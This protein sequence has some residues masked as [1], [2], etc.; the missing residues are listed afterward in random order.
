MGVSKFNN[1]EVSYLRKEIMQAV[2]TL[3]KHAGIKIELGNIRFTENE[4]STKMT[5]K[6]LDYAGEMTVCPVKEAKAAR[7][8]RVN[9][10]ATFHTGP[11]IGSLVDV[12]GIGEAKIIDFNSRASKVPFIVETTT[13]AKYRTSPM[14]IKAFL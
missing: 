2:K 6:R 8:I 7:S 12:L 1:Y 5:V 4:F 14:T 13:G 11:V 3:E 9:H 10:G